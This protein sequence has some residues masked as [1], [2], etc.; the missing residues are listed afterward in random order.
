MNNASTSPTSRTRAH[1]CALYEQGCASDQKERNTMRAQA[2]FYD[3]KVERESC[4]ER[5]GRMLKESNAGAS[6]FSGRRLPPATAASTAS[7]GAHVQT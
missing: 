5:Y 3:R 6:E 4:V 2:S 1:P 7:L